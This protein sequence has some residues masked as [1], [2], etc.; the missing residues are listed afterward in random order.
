VVESMD[1]V[2]GIL[3]AERRFSGEPRNAHGVTPY[4]T[5]A[6]KIGAFLAAAVI[7]IVEAFRLHPH[8]GTAA[9]CLTLALSYGIARYVQDERIRTRGGS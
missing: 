4:V 6:L 1:V 9:L 7:G 8:A 3:V 5:G 2:V